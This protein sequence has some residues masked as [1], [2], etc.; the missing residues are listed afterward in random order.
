MAKPKL[1][2]QLNQLLAGLGLHGS[3][4]LLI[5]RAVRNDW[6]A[7]EFIAALV[8]TTAFKAS[9]PGL[10]TGGRINDFLAGGRDSISASNLGSAITNYK[11][12]KEAYQDVA[13]VQGL[14]GFKITP[15]RMKL[16]LEAE[17]S[18]DE[19]GQE[20]MLMNVMNKNPELKA[21][22][23]QVRKEAG[24]K[25]ID[26]AEFFKELK[27]R[28]S[29]FYDLHEAAQLGLSGLGYS[30]AEAL[31]LAKGIGKPGAP[32]DVTQLVAAVRENLHDIGPELDR[33]GIGLTKLTAWMANPAVDPEGIT[34]NIQTL[35]AN[36]RQQGQAQQGAYGQE[37][38]GG[39]LA[40]VKPRETQSY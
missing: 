8:K 28:Q 14:T 35:I 27:N 21:W 18:P 24:L 17:K 32:A 30:P 15:Q 6:D 23:D 13:E 37:G 9:F 29:Q 38:P 39:G 36:R 3:Y 11:R 7:T 10:I 26:R 19:F 22:Y 16:L 20:A 33:Q 31:K 4:S 5:D 1:K 40:L 25:P 2:S 12:L 34:A